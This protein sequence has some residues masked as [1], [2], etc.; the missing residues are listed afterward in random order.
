M[1]CSDRLHSFDCRAVVDSMLA[2]GTA[3]PAREEC[4][5]S[6]D[7]DVVGAS[8]L[9]GG[10]KERSRELRSMVRDS[11]FRGGSG[12]NPSWMT[13][14]YRRRTVRFDGE[15]GEI[16]TT[17]CLGGRNGWWSPFHLIGDDRDQ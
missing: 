9:R 4:L 15:Y 17:R 2:L 10:L 8:A 7:S 12:R 3:R 6:G 13:L 16:T 5:N 11:G 14:G 1:A